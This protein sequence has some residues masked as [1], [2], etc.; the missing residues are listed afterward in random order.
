MKLIKGLIA[1]ALL[2]GLAGAGARAQEEREGDEEVRMDR[3]VDIDFK[4]TPFEQCLV[5]LS[6]ITGVNML[7]T[8]KAI[9]AMKD[10]PVT[11]TL[12]KTP[13]WSAVHLFA[14]SC[15]L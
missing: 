15:G 9:K 10:Q 5:S 2:A 3:R 14:R 11:F 8:Q 12:K 13:I 6:K 1:A 7:A 4:K